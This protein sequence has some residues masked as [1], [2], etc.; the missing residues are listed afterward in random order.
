MAILMRT[1]KSQVLDVAESWLQ[2]IR[3]FV[4]LQLH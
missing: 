2:I 4:L 3:A 1:S